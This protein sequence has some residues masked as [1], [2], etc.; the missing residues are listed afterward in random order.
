M[1]IKRVVLY[2]HDGRV[3]SLDFKLGALNIVTGRKG[4]GKSALIRIIEYCLGSTECNIPE[5]VIRESVSWYGL[6]LKFPDGEMFIARAEPKPGSRS[7]TH[8]FVDVGEKLELP[9]QSTLEQ[10][11]NTEALVNLLS[12][13]LGIANIETQRDSRSTQTQFKIT[14]AHA[15]FFTFQR[16]DEIAKPTLLFHRQDEAFVDSH[17]RDVLPYFLGAMTEDRLLL[18]QRLRAERASLRQLERDFALLQ[19]RLLDDPKAEAL[20]EE[21]ISVGL[22]PRDGGDSTPLERLRSLDVEAE[23]ML[24]IEGLEQE[25]ER[26]RDQRDHLLA[27]QRAARGRIERLKALNREEA[28]YDSEL[29]SQRARLRSIGLLPAER[30]QYCPLCDQTL[31]GRLPTGSAVRTSIERLTSQLENVTAAR[32][33]IEET[34]AELED[35]AAGLREKLR[36]NQETINTVEWRTAR[37]RAYRDEFAASAVVR[38][39]IQ[40]F[41]EN[42]RAS[43]SRAEDLAQRIEASRATVKE[44]EDELS[45][46]AIEEKMDSMLRFIEDDMSEWAR[47]MD[48]EYTT[49]VR[50]DPKHLTVVA[51]TR[52]GP[53]PLSRMGSGANW[54][55]YHVITYAALHRWFELNDR[56]VPRFI[57]FDQP[58]QSF[59]PPDTDDP[60][61]YANDDD[62]TRVEALFRFFASLPAR[63]NHKV[64]IIVT[65]HALLKMIEFEQAV[66]ENWHVVEA[67]VPIDWPRRG[68]TEGQQAT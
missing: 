18:V 65:D 57:V 31:S 47:E 34:I 55:G 60:E 5:G 56:P 10:N 16:Q 64:Q 68:P 2:S 36:S 11:S 3:R 61:A 53:L 12:S 21:A 59:F 62:R 22:A 28:G 13:R 19:P 4:T 6:L 30:N 58:T 32:P 7:S 17:I 43:D 25:L 33:K 50:L 67:L 45:L 14:I 63:L 9:A 37:M 40:F 1:Q 44:L 48:L 49:H 42:L 38:G 26:R 66:R 41:L 8:I 35:R 24:D 20:L 39:R 51:D 23:P 46:D 27:Q 15:L 29:D 52:N 54:V